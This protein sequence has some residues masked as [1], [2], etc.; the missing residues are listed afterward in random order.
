MRKIIILSLINIF[1][2]YA[3]YA[4]EETAS[5]STTT[6]S[7]SIV[8]KKGM[9]ILPAAGDFAIGGDALP[10]LRYVGNI[11][12]G[13]TN[14]QL[15]LGSATVM[16]RYF[17]TS[18]SAVRISFNIDN[19]YYVNRY[20]VDDEAAQFEDPFSQDKV[21]DQRSTKYQSWMVM[22]GFQ[23]FRG[24]GRLQGF[25]GAV[26]GYG[27]NRTIREYQYGNEMVEQNQSPLTSN[28]GGGQSNLQTRTLY[29]DGGLTREIQ[30]GPVVGVEFYFA[31]KMCIGAEA[32]ILMY[33][34][35]NTESNYT[36]E[37]WVDG[38]RQE[39]EIEDEPDEWERNIFSSGLGA[40]GGLY[41][42]FHF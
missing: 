29:D 2:V 4:Q 26:V 19:G 24:Y 9:A 27:Q 30:F 14:N 33:V 1:L 41:V 8:N 23:K 16:G 11:F 38:D 22:A 36:Y 32:N 15:N 28:F 7:S 18:Q 40:Y 35:M 25:Y 21:I 3:A 37:E 20:F 31:P 39:F 42:M 12:N 10:Y 6:S 13:N 5:V 34:N 17:L